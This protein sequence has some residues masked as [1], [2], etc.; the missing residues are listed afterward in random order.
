MSVRRDVP[1][2]QDA[3]LVEVDIPP[4]KRYC[5]LDPHTR[6]CKAQDERIVPR[7]YVSDFSITQPLS[8]R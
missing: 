3:A 4:L 6:P 8:L 7:E 5:F 2:D 1:P